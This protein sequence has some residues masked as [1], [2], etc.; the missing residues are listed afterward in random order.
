MSRRSWQTLRNTELSKAAA[1]NAADDKRHAPDQSVL[2][3]MLTGAHQSFHVAD[4]KARLDRADA[5]DRADVEARL[6]QPRPRI[7][8]G[9]D[10]P[11]E[12]A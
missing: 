9:D 6:A 8:L 4:V 10:E 12:V 5:R 3:K 2:T 7:D 1:R 11:P